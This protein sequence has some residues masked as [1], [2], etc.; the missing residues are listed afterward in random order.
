[1]VIQ[2]VLRVEVEEVEE[3]SDS[4]RVRAI[5]FHRYITEGEHADGRFRFWLAWLVTLLFISS[6]LT[7]CGLMG[8][9][10]K[11]QDKQDKILFLLSP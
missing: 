7:A 2:R 5:W 6:L 9:G 4:F 1:M 3:L 10:D 8:E 11:E